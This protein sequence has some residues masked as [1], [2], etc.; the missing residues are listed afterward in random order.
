MWLFFVKLDGSTIRQRVDSGNHPLNRLSATISVEA[1]PGGHG[2]LARSSASSGSNRSIP[3]AVGRHEGALRPITIDLEGATQTIRIF[4]PACLFVLALV[5][6]EESVPAEAP[7]AAFAAVR[8][9]L[10]R[11]LNDFING[12]DLSGIILAA[13]A[14]LSRRDDPAPVALNGVLAALGNLQQSIAQE[15]TDSCH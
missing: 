6:D 4:V 11:R 3:P 14:A 12:F 8:R 5:I 2:N 1:G 10:E 13:L 9:H 7:K 15:A